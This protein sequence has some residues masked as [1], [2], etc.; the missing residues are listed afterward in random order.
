MAGEFTSQYEAIQ[1]KVLAG[2]KEGATQDINRLQEELVQQN[3]L[4]GLTSCLMRRVRMLGDLETSAV[5]DLIKHASTPAQR[6]LLEQ[7]ALNKVPL[8]ESLRRLSFLLSLKPGDPVLDGDWGFGVIRRVDLFYAKLTIDYAVKA[9][10]IMTLAAAAENLNLAAEDHI[11]TR[12]Y[13]DRPALLAMMKEQPG[14]VLK[15]TVR[16]FGSLPVP[17]LEDLLC[18]SEIMTRAEW[19]T[20]WDAARKALK[21]DPLVVVPTKRTE[22]VQLLTAAPTFDAGWLERLQK[23]CDMKRIYKTLCAHCEDLKGKPVETEFVDVITD[24]LAFSL[25]GADNTDAPLYAAFVVLAKR[26]GLQPLPDE[27]MRAHLL[28]KN[29]FLTAAN[30]SGATLTRA[31]T[32]F[33]LEDPTTLPHILSLF[34]EMTLATLG[35]MLDVIGKEQL[36]RDTCLKLLQAP[37]PTPTLLV[38]TL[39]SYNA[40]LKDGWVL[41]PMMDLLMQAMFVIELRLSG[42]GL[43]MRNILEQFFDNAKWLDEVWEK[44]DA[45][46]QRMLFERIQASQSL[47]PSSQR[48]ILAHLTR[49]APSL[50]KGKKSAAL[51]E[52]DNTRKTSYRSIAEYQIVYERLV[53]YDMPKNANEIAAAREMGD[54]RENF[55]Y[56]SAKDQQRILLTRQA[57]LE[58]DFK[59]VKA[60][61]FADA[62]TDAVGP[63]VRVNY[64]DAGGQA[65]SY[66]ILGEWD[67]DEAL[68]IISCQTRL[69]KA[70]LGKKTGDTA[71]VPSAGGEEI[72]VTIEAILP[73]DETV[74]TWMSTIPEAPV[75]PELNV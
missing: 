53:K 41:P 56:Q 28:E 52:A 14:E 21:S 35:E 66:V 12:N 3:D 34:P 20:F 75:L 1:S 16:S 58:A 24:R 26:L 74:K 4:P 10:H 18:E 19:K 72:D 23:C 38:W 32:K 45:F 17:R 57:Q 22:P 6:I 25:K 48:V 37:T 70:L 29:R 63:G 69:A 46:Q 30:A 67:R 40:L 47:E 64:K 7:I 62:K 55:E 61:D 59:L 33:M 60:T 51:L 11:L 42:E 73:L 39:R 31:L 43:R 27:D 54:L 44:L 65:Y 71:K 36:T 68:N 9:G 50:S 5:R 8:E 49:R 2:D 15:M 13:R